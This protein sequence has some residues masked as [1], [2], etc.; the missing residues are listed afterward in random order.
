MDL[1]QSTAWM[2]HFRLSDNVSGF[3]SRWVWT[4]AELTQQM[5]DGTFWNQPLTYDSRTHL[6]VRSGLSRETL[7]LPMNKGRLTCFCVQFACAETIISQVKMVLSN[8]TG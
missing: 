6:L 5:T 3:R 7:C 1:D 2:R 8:I 4:R